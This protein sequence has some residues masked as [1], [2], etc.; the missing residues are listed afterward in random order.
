MPRGEAFIELDGEQ[1]VGMLFTIRAISQA[2]KKIG[3]GI[4]ALIAETQAG[5][6]GMEA[7]ATLLQ[8]GVMAYRNENGGKSKQATLEYAYDVIG[9]AG[10]SH[11]VEVIFEAIAD[12]LSYD[13]RSASGEEK[14]E[15][16][17][18]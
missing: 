5:T 13:S 2:E 16:P 3:T 9:A 11:A 1:Q 8:C 15:G 12:A 7:V 4:L 6:V 14:R 17:N 10:Y 18:D